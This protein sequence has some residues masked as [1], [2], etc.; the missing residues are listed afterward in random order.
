MF[1]I[2]CGAVLGPLL[3][4]NSDRWILTLTGLPTCR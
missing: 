3:S 1:A 4:S 2:H